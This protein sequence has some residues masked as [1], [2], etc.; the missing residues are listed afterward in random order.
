MQPRHSIDVGLIH[1][2]QHVHTVKAE[3]REAEATGWHRRVLHRQGVIRGASIDKVDPADGTREE[4]TLHATL[5]PSGAAC[6]V[7]VT[8][9]PGGGQ[10]VGQADGGAV[11]NPHTRKALEHWNGHGISSDGVVGDPLGD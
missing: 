4:V 3:I 8:P 11:M 10:R 6:C 7:V 1:S 5:Q 9:P 2:S